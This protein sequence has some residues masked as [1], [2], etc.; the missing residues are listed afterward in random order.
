MNEKQAKKRIEKLEKKIR[1]YKRFIKWA[2]N[3][4]DDCKEEIMLI[5]AGQG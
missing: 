5:E 1:K 3:K 2:K 4:I